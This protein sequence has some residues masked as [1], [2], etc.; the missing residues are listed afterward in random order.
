M[1]ECLTYP[2]ETILCRLL[3][4]GTRS[5]IDNWNASSPAKCY[6][7]IIYNYTGPIDCLYRCFLGERATEGTLGLFKGFGFLTLQFGLQLAFLKGVKS[8]YSH[9]YGTVDVSSSET[10]LNSHS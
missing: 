7:P 5:I 8:V 4:Q 3:V 1:T 10:R 2:L 9:Y 6:L